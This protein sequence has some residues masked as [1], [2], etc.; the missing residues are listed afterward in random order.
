MSCSSQTGFRANRF[1]MF[2]CQKWGFTS[3]FT[4]VSPRTK[5]GSLARGGVDVELRHFKD[6]TNCIRTYR[7]HSQCA[8]CLSHEPCRAASHWMVL[9]TPRET[10]V[11]LLRYDGYSERETSGRVYLAGEFG[12]SLTL[13]F[14]RDAARGLR[15]A[16]GRADVA[17]LKKTPGNEYRPESLHQYIH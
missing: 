2:R 15:P 4:P 13:D 5:T 12:F 14:T 16:R 8:R 10:R 17:H 11:C 3:G 6:E 1:V 7:N 9:V